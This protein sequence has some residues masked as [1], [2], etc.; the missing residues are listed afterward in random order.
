MNADVAFVV[1]VLFVPITRLASPL[2]EPLGPR[3][4]PCANTLTANALIA[5]LVTIIFFIH[6]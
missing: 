5:K 2:A 6:V 3:L 1:V 4:L